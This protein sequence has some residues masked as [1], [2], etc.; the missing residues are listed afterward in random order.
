MRLHACVLGYI[1]IYKLE[2]STV[3]VNIESIIY[4][5]EIYS[6]LLKT[7]VDRVYTTNYPLTAEGGQ[8]T[9]FNISSQPS[10]ISNT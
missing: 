6:W 1:H 8:E 7:V 9:A 2:E 10:R 3:L 4:E 5:W